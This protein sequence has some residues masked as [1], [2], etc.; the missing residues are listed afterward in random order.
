MSEE[1]GYRIAISR[2]EFSKL[3]TLLKVIENYC[4]DCDVQNGQLRCR[5]NDRQAVISMDLSS[6]LETNPLQFSLI[7]NKILLLKAFELD[8]NIQVED[9][10]IIIECNESNYRIQDPFSKIDFRKPAIKFMDN[11]YISDSEFESMIRCDEEKLML[12]HD[13]NNYLKHRISNITQGFQSDIIKCR[14]VEN[15]G[16]MTAE[17]RNHEDSAAFI[18]NITLNREVPDREFRMISMPFILDIAS[19]MKLNVYEVSNDIYMCKFD[20]VYYGV[21]IC[22]YTQV[23]VTNL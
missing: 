14:I 8:D 13:I 23:K 12:S 15:S 16:S 11:K 6:I 7:K 9:K 21:P 18:K 4:N 20:Q 5:T 2:D 1:N 3:L 10:N 17:T 19:D 22:V